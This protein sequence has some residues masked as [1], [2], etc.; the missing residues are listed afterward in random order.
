GYAYQWTTGD[1]TKTVENLAPGEYCVTLTDAHGCSEAGCVEV[2]PF[3]CGNVSVQISATPASCFGGT[4]GEAAVAV[5]GGTPPYQFLWSNGDTAAVAQNLTAQTYGVTITDDNGCAWTDAV[6]VGQ[7]DSLFLVLENLTNAACTGSATGSA[8]VSAAG[9][10]PGYMYLWSNGSVGPVLENVPPGMYSVTVSDDKGCENALD[11][12]ILGE[13]DTEPPVVLTQNITVTLHENGTATILPEMIDNGSFDNCQLVVKTLDITIFTCADVGEN[14]VTL[15]V[16]DAAGNSASA[17][18]IVTVLDQTPPILGC[19]G[20]IFSNFCLFAVNYPEPV[21]T[22]A[23]GVASLELIDGLPSGSVFPFG[24][25]F[26]RYRATDISGNQ[27]TCLFTVTIL[28][29]MVADVEIV[30]PACAGLTN[31]SA[32]VIVDGGTPPFQY[33]WNDPAMQQ[34]PEVINLGAGFYSVTITDAAGCQIGASVEVTEPE[35]LT[36]QTEGT[37]PGCFGEATGAATALPDGGTPPYAFAWNDPAGQMT[38]TASGLPAGD[39]LVEVTDSNGCVV[40]GMISLDE[41]PALVVGLDEIVHASGPNSDGAIFVTPAGGTPGYT[42][43]WTLDG[44]FFSNQEDLTQ[45][46]PGEYCLTLSDENGC[47][48]TTCFVIEMINSTVSSE[49]FTGL[50]IRPNPTSERVRVQ[51]DWPSPEPLTLEVYDQLGR[52]VFEQKSASNNRH[53]LDWDVSKWARGVYFVQIKLKEKVV[54]RKLVVS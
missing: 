17:P 52:L 48:E 45:L 47:Q 16:W 53:I 8:T 41:P 42:F 38:Q 1:T 28:S 51:V 26:V 37:P 33:Q 10:T 12:E 46:A 6:T 49:P 3:L 44:Q 18:A 11:I 43:E 31:G 2:L 15:T 36:T 14:E 35:V 9:G 27:A 23:C 54:V 21:A 5:S 39:Y 29:D 7:P 25:T 40:E 50:S 19:P 32:T 30:P 22:D 34:T 20:D 24:T 13:N 4:D